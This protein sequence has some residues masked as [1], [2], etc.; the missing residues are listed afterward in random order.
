MNKVIIINIAMSKFFKNYFYF[1]FT[2]VVIGVSTPAQ[3][4]KAMK[5]L[6]GWDETGAF[7]KYYCIILYIL[8]SVHHFIYILIFFLSPTFS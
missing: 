7:R 8:H 2:C 5:N 3:L 4:A 1:H 6:I